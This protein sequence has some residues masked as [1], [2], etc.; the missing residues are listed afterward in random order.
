MKLELNLL[1]H[2]DKL[3]KRIVSGKL[4]VFDL[5]RKKYVVATP[6]EW[7]RQL[8]ILYLVHEKNININ[9]IAVEK[10]LMINQ[11]P[12]RFDI[13]IF[14]QDH[15]PLTIIECKS[16]KISISDDTFRQ[17]S[18]YNMELRAPFL[19]VTNGMWTYHC[20]IDFDNKSYQFLTDI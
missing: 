7:V 8:F 4:Q 16:P 10:Q 5:V 15:S 19:I 1:I 3:K 2:E 13:V 14:A 11:L 9:K 20:A 6:E 18:M 17:A 12:K